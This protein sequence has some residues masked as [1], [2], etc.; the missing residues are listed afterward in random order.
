MSIEIKK[1]SKIYPNGTKAVNNIDLKISKGMIGLLGPNGAGKTTLMKI[2]T[3]ILRK[4]KGEVIIYSKNIEEDRETIR[5]LTGY[6]PQQY[7]LYENLNAI[8][9]LDYIGLFY[10]MKDSKQRQKRIKYLLERVNLANVSKKKLNSYSGG[11]KRRLG[12]AQ[13]LLNN[14]KLL[15]VDEP[16]A[17]LDPEE[18]IKFRNLLR[19][20]LIEDKERIIIL[21][22]HIVND[23]T[24]LCSEIAVLNN[25]KLVYRGNI[26]ELNSMAEGKVWGINTKQTSLKNMEKQ[27]KIIDNNVLNDDDVYLKILSNSQPEG[28][29]KLKPELEA[30][31]VWLLR[32]DEI[33]NE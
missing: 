29:K 12:I 24:A 7:G 23:I 25:G 5:T 28:A 22:T 26:E 31:Y 15:I 11:M 10:N 33:E 20:L 9:F 1:L 2:L 21:S 27:F 13:A 32:E 14:P 3:G 8:E 6:L 17:G 18:K 16:T 4:T 30:S 19:D